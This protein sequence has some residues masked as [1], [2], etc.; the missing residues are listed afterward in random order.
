MAGELKLNH[1]LIFQTT[2]LGFV[3]IASNI[4]GFSGA[5]FIPFAVAPEIIEIKQILPGEN[6]KV[7]IE[8]SMTV[9][10]YVRSYFSDIPVMI[11]IAKCE[12]R[13]RQHDENGKVLRGEKN[14]S[15]RGV[16]QINKDFH[17]DN[18][19]KLG[20]DIMTLEGNTAYGRHLFEKYGVKPWKSSSKCWSKTIAYSEYKDLAI[21]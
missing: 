3:M 2:V 20:Y 5:P 9:E 11:E 14:D 18:S 13:F 10:E 16:M 7:S 1:R 15:D 21:K 12:S 6:K 19:E 8:R 17:N 4:A